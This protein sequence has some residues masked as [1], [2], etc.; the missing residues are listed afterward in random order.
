MTLHLNL[1]KQYFD[2]H[3]NGKNEEYREVTPYWIKRLMLF[4]GRKIT[5]EMCTRMLKTSE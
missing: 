1:I 3:L 4:N 2:L 5:G